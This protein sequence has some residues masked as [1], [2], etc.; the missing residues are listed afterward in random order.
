MIGKRILFLSCLFFFLQAYSQKI[1]P[2]KPDLSPANFRLDSLPA[3]EINI[4]IQVNLK[5][6]FAMAEKS[7]DT[8]FTSPKY[9]DEWVQEACDIRYKYIFRRSPLQIRGSGNTLT[10]GFTG[11]YKIIG[12]TR[13]CVKGT[14]VSPWTPACKCGF[15][16]PERRVNVSFTSAVNVQPDYK[17]RLYVK[18]NDPQP[19]DKCEVCFW[20]TDITKQV[21]KGLTLELDASK[22]DLEK[23]YGTVDL[24]SRFQ[25]VWDQLN[26]VYNL[27]GLGWLQ[28][29]PQSFRVNNLFVL[30]D[31][32]NI[33]LGLSAK[34]VVSLEKPAEKSSWVPN[35]AS[36]S[37][38]KGFA[39]FLDAMLNYDS[40]GMIMNKN[41]VG[42]EFDF[43][44][45]FV[46]KKFILD[47]CKVYG[48]GSDKLVIKINFSGTNT[49]IFYLTGKPVYDPDKKIIDVK[50]IDFDIKSKNILL[51]S[52]DWLFDKKITKEIS[53]YA[54]FE[55]GAYIDTAKINMNQQLNRELTKGVR[56]YGMIK[57]IRLVG[58]YPLQQHLV[59]RSSCEGELSVKIESINFSF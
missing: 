19:L 58:I 14:V 18:R 2:A 48:G 51:G 17:V 50:D 6:L 5:P 41:L 27:Y 44:K 47:S 31:S 46:K 49:G 29:N 24:R 37:S 39:I 15:N 53:K 32:L 34:P 25:Q 22:K 38:Q 9:P 57:D 56:S 21:M 4:P 33:Y 59:I 1:D 42:K 16:E 23:N 8:V 43:K 36:T 3:S 40:L 55:L 20:G 7:V 11:Y 54:R 45:G 10:L 30:K 26:K 35:M 52:A 12:S 28:I 13:V